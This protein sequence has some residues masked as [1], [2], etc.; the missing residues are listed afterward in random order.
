[1][2]FSNRGK[3]VIEKL[4]KVT[5]WALN[6][7]TLG[8]QNVIDN[9]IGAGLGNKE[10]RRK[11]AKR[12][13]KTQIESGQMEIFQKVGTSKATIITMKKKDDRRF[14]FETLVKKQ[15]KTNSFNILD[16]EFLFNKFP[17]YTKPKK[18]FRRFLEDETTFKFI[19]YK[20]KSKTYQIL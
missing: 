9:K 4:N 14:R 5:P 8:S 2:E 19:G 3:E 18:A 17:E 6:G 7:I 15:F 1:M 13:H 11:G 10:S 20:N 12:S 16:L